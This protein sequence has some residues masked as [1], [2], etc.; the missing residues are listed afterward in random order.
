MSIFGLFKRKRISF[1]DRVAALLQFA[2]KFGRGYV[3]H[4]LEN[5]ESL[6]Y[7]ID[8][9]RFLHERLI[10]MF[11]LIDKFISDPERKV[12]AAL[13]QKYFESTGLIADKKSMMKEVSFIVSRYKEY[14]DS[15]NAKS[16]EQW[17]LG[18]VIA[19]NYLGE[20]EPANITKSLPVQL[21][22]GL[23]IKHLL[24]FRKDIGM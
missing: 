12:M 9:E 5:N 22:L 6:F 21:D 15:W 3:D 19:K 14:H 10:L 8:R 18:S 7:G 24:D 23:T 20:S 2:S 4:E 13:H 16:S 1:N 17:L 11:W